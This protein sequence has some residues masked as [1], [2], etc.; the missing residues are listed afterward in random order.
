MR[1]LKESITLEHLHVGI[2]AELSSVC[3]QQKNKKSCWG[4]RMD[5]KNRTARDLANFYGSTLYTLRIG[6]ASEF[7]VP[8]SLPPRLLSNY[9]HHHHHHLITCTNS[10]LLHDMAVP[11][12]SHKL[13][14]P[15]SPNSI[16]QPHPPTAPVRNSSN[17]VKSICRPNSTQTDG[18]RKSR[19]PRPSGRLV[20]DTRH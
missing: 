6:A 20:R 17:T 13:H 5:G 11:I 1:I 7:V 15:S 14:I 4:S 9:F 2:P 3:V 16:L 10:H 19:Y 12:I 8:S 18:S